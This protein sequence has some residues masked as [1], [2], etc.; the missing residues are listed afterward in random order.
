MPTAKRKLYKKTEKNHMKFNYNDDYN[1]NI[2]FVVKIHVIIISFLSRL[3]CD[4]LSV[5]FGAM[6]YT[7]KD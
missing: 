7:L 2:I 6:Q 3:I 1:N 5:L 4:T